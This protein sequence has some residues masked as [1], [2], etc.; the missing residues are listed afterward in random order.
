MFHVEGRAARVT[1]AGGFVA[2]N[3][4]ACLA[5]ARAGHGIAIC[6]DVNVGDEL[7][8]GQLTR[9]LVPFSGKT[10]PIQTVR[11]PSA[12]ESPKVSAFTEA[13]RAELDARRR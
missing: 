8:T 13:L 2:N 5:L 11:L 12:F 7:R 6:L 1:V 10:L 3:A 9:L 4:R